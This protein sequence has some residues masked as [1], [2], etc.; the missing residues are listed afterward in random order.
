VVCG[1]TCPVCI[2][3]IFINRSGQILI[4]E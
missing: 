2:V 4:D 1:F 3:E